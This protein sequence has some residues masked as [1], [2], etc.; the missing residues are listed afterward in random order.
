MRGGERTAP[1]P[2]LLF[3]E[4]GREPAPP[5]RLPRPRR[6][7][8]FCFHFLHIVIRQGRASV[9][10]NAFSRSGEIQ[11]NALSPSLSGAGLCRARVP[12]VGTIRVQPVHD[13]IQH[14]I[15]RPQHALT[16]ATFPQKD[17]GTDR[18]SQDCRS[19]SVTPPPRIIRI[20]GLS[21]HVVPIFFLP[22]SPS[23]AQSQEIQTLRAEARHLRA[24]QLG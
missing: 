9:T 6:P 16:P 7:E 12:M 23:H 10:H 17:K 14:S 4:P 5:R 2:S 20:I 19:Y 15:V 22:G 13:A 1:F 8:R 18:F 11:E 24:G 21:H 3:P